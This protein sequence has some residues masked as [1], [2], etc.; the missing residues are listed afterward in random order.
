M[1]PGP[2]DLLRDLANDLPFERPD[3]ARRDAIRSSLLVEA[4]ES[5]AA[6]P[7]ASRRWPVALAFAAG[8]LAAAAIALTVLRRP[9][10][11]EHPDLARITA[12]SPTVR[13]EHRVVATDTGVD[14]IVQLRDGTVA[15][16]I[17]AQRL[18]DHVRIQ[19][20]TAEVEGDAGEL[21]VTVAA[22]QLQSVRVKTGTARVIVVGQTPVTL[23]AG[24]IW[25]A[26]VITTELTPDAPMGAVASA[27]PAPAKLASDQPPKLAVGSAELIAKTETPA[28]PPQA[29]S[30]AVPPPASASS[31][32][33]ATTMAPSIVTPSNARVVAPPVVPPSV[34]V[35][36]S[37]APRVAAPRVP[38]R[39]EPVTLMPDGSKPALVVETATPSLVDPAKVEP[40]VPHKPA[41]IEHEFQQGFALLKA[42]K[43]REAALA[44]GAAADAAPSA[45]LAADARYFQAVALVRANDP[46]SAER[47]LVQFLDAAPRSLRRGRAAILLGR[48]LAERGDPKSAR[49]W[50]E[51]AANDPDP[52]IAAA[53]KAGL[54]ALP[55]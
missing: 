31:A 25:R 7:T 53:A 48:L 47:I 38:A 51:T 23:S 44:L 54:Q 52:A 46:R 4:A 35:A 29:A 39:P 10:P 18:G 3:A 14:E 26:S 16:A 55:K 36:P 30:T 17:P 43:A 5:T 20:M 22:D 40:T 21:E 33:L 41:S 49:S 34:A 8:A 32:R 50:L 9:A 42:G 37:S 28:T 13:L 19:T 12:S 24:Q 15:L 27:D 11:V 45:P 6:R 1:T 2:D